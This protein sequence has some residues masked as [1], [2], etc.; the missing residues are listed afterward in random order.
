MNQNSG[1]QPFL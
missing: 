1:F